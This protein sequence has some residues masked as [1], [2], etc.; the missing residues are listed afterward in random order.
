MDQGDQMTSEQTIDSTLRQA[1]RLQAQTI[2]L[3][4]IATHNCVL[5]IGA[6]SVAVVDALW[7]PGQVGLVVLDGLLILGAA[8]VARRVM[9]EWSAQRF[10][11][12]RVAR[13]IERRLQLHGNPLT[14]AVQLADVPA[15][16]SEQL[17][18]LAVDQGAKVASTADLQGV[19]EP[20][21]T[22]RRVRQLAVAVVAVVGLSILLPGLVP[23]AA[24]R[25]MNPS[26]DL[27]AFTLLQFEISTDPGVGEVGRPLMIHTQI[28]G[29]VVPTEAW[30]VV[31]GGGTAFQTHPM[32]A[33][34]EGQFTFR[35][36]GSK[37]WRR[38]HVAT[39]DGR[40]AWHAISWADEPKIVSMQLRLTSPA[41]TQIP[42]RQTPYRGQQLRVLAG[43]RVAFSIE[44]N[45]ALKAVRWIDPGGRV[46]EQSILTPSAA[47]TWIE[48]VP[49]VSGV[50]Q[51]EPVGV[52]DVAG[53]AWH[54][55]LEVEPDKSPV[56]RLVE[57]DRR[58]RVPVGWIVPVT[59][60]VEDD[61]AVN[62][63]ELDLNIDGRLSR[64]IMILLRQGPRRATATARLDLASLGAKVGSTIRGRARAF[65]RRDGGGAG[66]PTA[67]FELRLISA[68]A[69]RKHVAAQ[70]GPVTLLERIDRLIETWDKA[71][72]ARGALLRDKSA[73]GDN[74]ADLLKRYNVAAIRL[75]Q[76]LD[77][78]L[79]LESENSLA[80][81]WQKTLRPIRSTAAVWAA[82]RAE[83]TVDRLLKETE[84]ALESRRVLV[85]ARRQVASVV[86]MAR[87]VDAVGRVGQVAE[88][89]RAVAGQ[90]AASADPAGHAVEQQRLANQ[91]RLAL[92]DLHRT[93]LLSV[94]ISDA[95]AKVATKSHQMI[96]SFK[97]V[98]DQN[99]AAAA[100][101]GGQKQ[102]A[103]TYASFAATK[104][105]SLRVDAVQGVQS[106]M[107][108]PD[109]PLGISRAELAKTLARS[110][111]A[112]PPAAPTGTG[113]WSS[114]PVVGPH[115]PKR[116]EGEGAQTL[117]QSPT[118]P[119][120]PGDG[121]KT[122]WFT[123]D[124]Y[125]V[126]GG[127][128]RVGAQPLYRSLV[129]QY[130]RRLAEDDDSTQGATQ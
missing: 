115:T 18:R 110:A 93:A 63:V 107:K 89:Q 27:P 42:T 36:V 22:Q 99:Q 106:A 117:G 60:D 79:W 58:V 73:A 35:L 64:Q 5:L 121:S 19:I 87:V 39:P 84:T 71:S 105:E 54:I 94:E 9:Q 122:Q 1:G 8:W 85:A 48:R 83:T 4:S 40:S 30:V 61:V 50:Y 67:S 126:G 125:E 130:L 95:L 41:Y 77:D 26:G 100:A 51:L 45:M 97:I 25:L 2:L 3:A 14:N 7:A 128:G 57:P 86:L 62:R 29:P 46:E 74:W 56:V 65:D 52:N 98:E 37:Q 70:D 53:R 92:S 78:H 109:G 120:R 124:G 72:A 103:S 15:G 127:A 118:V 119:T 33:V 12:V 111:S 116:V 10:D 104:L 23:A 59:V 82:A 66:V 101:R 69:Y 38:F 24:A 55:A 20:G 31:D 90:L 108:V 17:C 44:T 13:L 28:D 16:T 96:A 34:G 123:P 11:P 32:I 91:L 114:T 76:D 43:T 112:R 80:A 102:L 68:E 49:R 47:E 81:S 21:L 88:P 6:W 75:V 113:Q 129:E